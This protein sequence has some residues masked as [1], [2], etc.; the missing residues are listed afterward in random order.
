MSYPVLILLFMFT[1]FSGQ[2]ARAQAPSPEA[3]AI[4]GD[5]LTENGRA[6]VRIQKTKSGK[7]VGT[8]VWLKEP[9]N[10]QGQ[11]KVDKNNPDETKRTR[12]ILSMRNLNG[13][14]HEGEQ[15]WSGGTIYD[16]ESGNDYGCTMKLLDPK[17]LEV[18]GYVGVSLFGRTSVWTR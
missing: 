14:G 3:D 16:P 4:L 12:P 2:P 1:L 5:W 13:M 15:V 9:L 10:E 8:I 7:Y 11:P 18:R 17:T 6:R